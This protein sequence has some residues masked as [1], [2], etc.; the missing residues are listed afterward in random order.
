VIVAMENYSV[1][2]EGSE[3]IQKA[4]RII[5][6]YLSRLARASAYGTYVE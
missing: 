5:Y 2:N 6:D 1:G 3:M 4:S